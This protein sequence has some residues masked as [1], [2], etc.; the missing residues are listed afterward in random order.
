MKKKLLFMLCFLFLF[1]SCSKQTNERDKDEQRSAKIIYTDWSEGIAISYLV[2]NVLEQNLDYKITLKLDDLDNIYER[3]AVGEYDL[4]L[5]A[6]LPVTHDEYF[7]MYADKLT[8]A[9]IVYEGAQAGLVVPEYMEE[10][11]LDDLKTL[12]PTV[13]AIGESSGVV[14]NARKATE[15]YGFKMELLTGSEHKMLQALEDG[16]KRREPVIITG[17]T[18]HQMFAKYDLRFLTDE[19]NIFGNEEK[20]YSLANATSLDKDRVLAKFLERFTLTDRQISRLIREVL[21][22]PEGEDAGARSWMQK[23]RIIVSRW[24]KNLT[25]FEDK[26]L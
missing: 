1:T 25:E 14:K 5:D 26:A 6:W 10:Q 20:I 22:H 21:S 4:F 3:V 24:T 19:K 13:Y 2:K 9:G 8:K 23:N 17:W 12:N 7:T 11:S 18:P 15:A 16:Y